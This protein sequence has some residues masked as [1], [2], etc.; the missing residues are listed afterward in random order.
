M[1]ELNKGPRF[2]HFPGLETGP[3]GNLLENQLVPAQC[4]DGAVIQ[5][6]LITFFSSTDFTQRTKSV[7]M[8]VKTRL[9]KPA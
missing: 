7:I 5:Q 6:N 3:A 1:V 9:E 4:R 2:P 8:S